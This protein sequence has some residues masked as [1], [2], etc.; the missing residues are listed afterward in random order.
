MVFDNE[1][2]NFMFH[3]KHLLSGRLVG[4]HCS[5]VSGW[6]VGELEHRDLRPSKVGDH[7]EGHAKYE[8]ATPLSSILLV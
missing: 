8:V 7:N 5:T 6:L 1:I 2:C 3:F 4:Q